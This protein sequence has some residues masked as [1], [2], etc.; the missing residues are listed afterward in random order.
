[1]SNIP[2]GISTWSLNGLAPAQV[3]A[4][5]D[6]QPFNS[7]YA[8]AVLAYL[9][10]KYAEQ[11]STGVEITGD[12]AVTAGFRVSVQNGSVEHDF[13]DQSISDALSQLIRPHLAEI[14]QK[15]LDQRSD[16]PATE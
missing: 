8:D 6:G 12:G 11:L 4:M 13:T 16:A 10:A 1:M 2:L 5:A 9:T 7:E 14:V 3:G 15:T